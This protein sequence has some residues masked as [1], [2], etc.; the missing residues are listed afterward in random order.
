MEDLVAEVVVE[1]ENADSEVL[2]LLRRKS[3]PSLIRYL[4]L[5][6]IFFVG[7]GLALHFLGST[8][9]SDAFFIIGTPMFF[10]G[11]Y[12]L[13]IAP[14]KALKEAKQK[15]VRKIRCEITDEHVR[16]QDVDIDTTMNW[17]VIECSEEWKQH[18][19][20]RSSRRS[21]AFAIPKR[22]F[23]SP[24]DESL[25]R[26]LLRTHTK[27]KLNPNAALDSAIVELEE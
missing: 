14:K 22:S 15:G 6:G 18:Y 20:L 13:W 10:L 24:H 16:I 4:Y 26:Q 25:F 23:T 21:S 2:T 1:F 5:R 7:S 11:I 9:L 27:T 3:L 19:I 12:L 8:A 17:G